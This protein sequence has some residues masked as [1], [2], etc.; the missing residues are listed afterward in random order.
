MKHVHVTGCGR[1][2][3]TLLVEMMRS[4]FKCD[5]DYAHERSILVPPPIGLSVYITKCPGEMA[6]FDR[7][8]DADIRLHGIHV[9][10]DPRSVVSSVHGKATD[11]YATNFPSWKRNQI[12]ARALRPHPRFLEVRYEQLIADPNGVQDAVQRV[13]PFLERVGGFSSYHERALPSADALQ[14]LNGLREV[15][16]GRTEPWRHHLGRIKEQLTLYPEMADM[17]I[18]LGYENDKAWTECLSDVPVSCFRAW[19]DK[20]LHVLKK[21]DRWQRQ[22]RRL[23]K[24]LALLQRDAQ[25]ANLG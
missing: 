20:G 19:E 2:G 3:T 12:L 22:R 17:L 5:G 4:S 1:S 6:F 23:L 13:W 10:R 21:F 11:C 16:I 7:L 18:E 24:R 14:A 25:S 9:Y 8:L 15:D